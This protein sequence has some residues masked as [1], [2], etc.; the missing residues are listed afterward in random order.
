MYITIMKSKI[1]H[2]TVTQADLTYEGSITID[3]DLMQ[4][5]NI[6][7]GERVQIVNLT[8]GERLETYTII[9]EAGSGIIGLNGPAALKCRK[10]DKIHIIS[11]AMLKASEAEKFK[12]TVLI[13]NDENKIKRELSS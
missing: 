12:N 4:R 7:S 10:D 13:L 5:A 3:E 2:V 6:I 8:N 1:H 11:Y 9:G